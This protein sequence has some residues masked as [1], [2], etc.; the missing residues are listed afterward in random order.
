MNSINSGHFVRISGVNKHDKQHPA[1]RL[2]TKCQ[3][4][5]SST[6]KLTFILDHSPPS[7]RLY[8]YTRH[9]IKNDKPG[10]HVF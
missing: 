1:P 6:E 8:Y 4:G 5:A 9:Q 7:D 2:E 10:S 3:T